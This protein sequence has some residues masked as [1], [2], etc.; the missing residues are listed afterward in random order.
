MAILLTP[1]IYV[2]EKKIENYLGTDVARRM[3]RA[4]MGHDEESYTNIP[5]AG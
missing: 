3:K 1:V 2:A 4:A 5:A